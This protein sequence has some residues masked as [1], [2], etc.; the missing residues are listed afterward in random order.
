MKKTFISI[1][2]FLLVMFGLQA[3]TTDF[4]ALL[5]QIDQ[6]S[7]FEDK[8]FA[9]TVNIVTKRP[10]KDDDAKEMIFRRRDKDDKF[11]VLI[12]K[13]AVERGQGL[14]K[15]GDN[16]MFYDPGT[17]ETEH[18]SLKESFAGTGA[19]NDDFSNSSLS[20]DYRVVE[21][22]AE[23]IGKQEVWALTLEAKDS[24]VPVAKL[25][26][27]VARGGVPLLLKTE[28]YSLS[29]K[30]MRTNRF[31]DYRQ[32]D[33]RWV[34]HKALFEDNLNVGEKTQMTLKDVSFARIPDN[35]FS[36]IYLKQASSK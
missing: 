21:G 1:S 32:A 9:S 7:N 16:L 22:K 26:I 4:V 28:E 33:G 14:L 11:L 19:R 34:Y 23:M 35:V 36:E 20:K 30:L 8:D 2:M 6:I 15:I 29:G 18:R 3:Q 5:A 12:N 31:T 17:G 24:S 25:K 13:P 10:G 27:W